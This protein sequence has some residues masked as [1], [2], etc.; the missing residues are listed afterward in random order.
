M[1]DLATAGKT[2]VELAGEAVEALSA[3]IK[4]IGLDTT[5]TQLGLSVTDDILHKVANS[6]ILSAGN[7]RQLARPEVFSLLAEVV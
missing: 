5:F 4:D 7:A 2:T 1:F 3:F 6:C